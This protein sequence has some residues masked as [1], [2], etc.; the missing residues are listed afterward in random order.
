MGRATALAAAGEGAA[1][2][3]LARRGDV[4]DSVV[5]E[6]TAAGG[7]AAPCVAD[8]TSETETAAAVKMLT[9]RF[10]RLDAL[11]N[12][13][14]TNIAERSLRLI[15]ADH[16][17]AVLAANLDA[18]FVLTRSVLPTFRAQG[19][20]LIVHVSSSA[21]KRADLAGVAYHAAKAGIAG[22]AHATMEEER[23]SGVRVSVIFPGLTDTPLVAK[24]PEPVPPEVMALAMQPEDVAAMCVALLALPARAYVPELLLYPSRL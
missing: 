16:W 20:G 4:V 5:G 15:D 21:A 6:I 8:A 19:D 7:E 10:G 2:G 17:R 22:L 9:E 1:V 23:P 18:G 14:G 12:C 3:V 11:V 24:R 13:V